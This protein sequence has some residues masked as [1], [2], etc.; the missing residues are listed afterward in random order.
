VRPWDGRDF[1]SINWASSRVEIPAEEEIEML[2]SMVTAL[3]LAGS[4][5]GAIQAQPPRALENIYYVQ[6]DGMT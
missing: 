2:L 1:L 6:I 3:W 5:H 4:T